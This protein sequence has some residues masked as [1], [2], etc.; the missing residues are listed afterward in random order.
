MATNEQIK[1]YIQKLVKEE[2]EKIAPKLIRETMARS[3][4]QLI[5]EASD[6]HELEHPST[7]APVRGNSEKRRA[8]SEAVGMEEFPTMGKATYTTDRMS[9]VINR[10][11]TTRNDG[12]ITID[13]AMTENGN[14]VPITSVATPEALDIVTKAMNKDYRGLLKSLDR[15]KA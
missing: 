4:G 3:I 9:E 5:I 11:V 15:N 12:V 10:K 2:V 14:P 13:Q 6:L 1:A 7:P 8:L